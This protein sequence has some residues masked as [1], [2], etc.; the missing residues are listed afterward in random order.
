MTANPL[1]DT[2]LWDKNCRKD[3]EEWVDRQYD[4]CEYTTLKEA[5]QDIMRISCGRVNPKFV[6][7]TGKRRG[8]E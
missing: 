4:L 8:L 5:L 2:P 1:P 3:V 6:L 7:D